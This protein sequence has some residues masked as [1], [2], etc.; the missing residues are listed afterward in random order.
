MN[1]LDEFFLSYLDGTMSIAE[2]SKFEADLEA[3]PALK[4]QFFEFKDLYQQLYKVEE[5]KEDNSSVAIDNIMLEL[6]KQPQ[7]KNNSIF[8]DSTIYL[9]LGASAILLVTMLWGSPEPT[10]EKEYQHVYNDTIFSGSLDLLIISIQGRIGAI[11]MLGSGL[12]ALLLVIAKKFR[13]ALVFIFIAIV[14]FLIRAVPAPYRNDPTVW[15]N[16]LCG[17]QGENC[18]K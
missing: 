5:P 1:S 6:E 11:V 13:F 17:A 8:K 3:S 12:L 10:W 14:L 4:Q 16:K 15:I 18:K 2:R 9:A 7:Y